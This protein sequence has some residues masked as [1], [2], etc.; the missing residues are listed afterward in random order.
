MSTFFFFS[1]LCR[2][3]ADFF[4][5]LSVDRS[6]VGGRGEL[7]V[8]SLSPSSPSL[9]RPSSPPS[10]F[11]FSLQ[12]WNIDLSECIRIWRSGCIIQSDG[13]S[14][15]LQPLLSSSSSSSSILNPLLLPP[16]ASEIS[17]T[18]PSLK[19]VAQLVLQTD[20]VAP[21]L[22]A[23]LEWVKAVGG[24]DLPTNYEEMQLDTFGAHRYD[25]KGELVEGAKKGPYQ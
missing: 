17:K 9:P 25:V 12:K 8:S 7:S 2:A 23:T 11:L 14:D 13:I 6:S 20:A 16:L 15:F 5:F 19:S 1:W 4:C 22:T 18:Y 21:A 24:K 3:F 10:Q